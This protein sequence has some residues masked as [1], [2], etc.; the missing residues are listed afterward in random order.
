MTI[1]RK[2]IESQVPQ[3]ADESISY[4]FDSTPWGSSPGSVT[5]KV[6]DSAG[7]DKSATLLTGSAVVVDDRVTLPA[8]SG[9]TAGERYKLTVKFTSGGN[10]FSAYCYVLAEA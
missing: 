1:S 2:F 5:V 7:T 3:G 10:I 4:Y 6:Y 9:L 8:L